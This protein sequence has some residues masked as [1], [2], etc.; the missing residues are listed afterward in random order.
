[1]Y[2][3]VRDHTPVR[4]RIRIESCLRSIPD[5]LAKSNRKFMYTRIDSGLESRKPA[6]YY[7]DSLSWMDHAG[8]VTRCYALTSPE[9]PLESFLNLKQFK[10]YMSDTGLLMSMYGR[11]TIMDLIN[12]GDDVR[13]GAIVENEVAECIT[14][15]GYRASYLS[16]NKGADRLEIDFVVALGSDVTAIE[17][18]SGKDRSASSLRKVDRVYPSVTRKIKF[19]DCNIHRDDECE[20]YPLFAAAFIDELDPYSRVELISDN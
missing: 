17:V 7:F 9:K 10:V 3:D 13:V 4:M 18:K 2:D 14:K 12:G 15:A 20:H 5:Q 19:E 8:M 1:M 11:N 6:S 16:R